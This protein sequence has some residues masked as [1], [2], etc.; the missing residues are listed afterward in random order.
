MSGGGSGPDGDS[1][2]NADCP[3]AS[4]VASKSRSWHACTGRSQPTPSRWCEPGIAAPAAAKKL[5]TA[6]QA[7][8]ARASVC[9]TVP[10]CRA[11]L[12]P[13]AFPGRHHCVPAQSSASTTTRCPSCTARH[14]VAIVRARRVSKQQEAVGG[15]Q[16]WRGRRIG[17][18]INVGCA[19]LAHH[20]LTRHLGKKGMLYA[21]SQRAAAHSKDVHNTYHLPHRKASAP[22]RLSH[23]NTT[24]HPAT[25]PSKRTLAPVLRERESVCVCGGGGLI[26]TDLK[27]QSSV[28]IL[29]QDLLGG[30]I[31]RVRIRSLAQGLSRLLP[32][33][34]SCKEVPEG[35]RHQPRQSK[36]RRRA[37]GGKGN[38]AVVAKAISHRR[39]QDLGARALHRLD[40]VARQ[41]DLVG[42]SQ[43]SRADSESP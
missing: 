37:E 31:M 13:H 33:R 10:H 20:C 28:R 15:R 40:V 34:V 12:Y 4:V 1:R 8:R 6:C 32:R 17:S 18:S 5:S 36:R 7:P 39:H 22:L 3:I 41:L 38:A 25:P 35:M 26:N 14:R 21:S 30:S 2:A 27:R 43:T 11:C 42:C 24:H 29:G 9:D 16:G 19:R 23:V